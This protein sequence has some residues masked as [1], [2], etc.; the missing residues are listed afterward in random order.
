MSYQVFTRNWWEEING[1]LLSDHAAEKHNIC[2]F[3][4]REDARDYCV[5]KN[6]NLPVSWEKLGRKYE[7]D[8]RC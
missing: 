1:K 2:V 8:A 3:P 4:T 6:E 5:S 7:F